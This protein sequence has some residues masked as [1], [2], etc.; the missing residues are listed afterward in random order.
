VIPRKYPGATG[1][2][3]G[4]G[5]S[6]TDADIE[7]IRAARQADRG[8]VFAANRAHEFVPADVIHGCNYQFWHRWWPD[9]R[10]HPADR[11]TT[12]PELE[13]IYPGLEYIAERWEPG[14]S[15]DPAWIAAHHG[16][17]PQL[18]NIAYLYGCTRLLLVGWDMRFHGKQDNRTYVTRR[19]LGE[20]DLTLQHWP[21]TGPNGELEGLI[22]E[23]ET[24]RPAEYGIEI[25]NCTPGSAL[26]CFPF[27]EIDRALAT[28]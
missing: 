12:R 13:G 9:L 3:V 4:T 25:I 7:A 16:T 11:W 10:D 24:I 15:R 20:D 17:G 19:Y 28:P 27:M 8:R 2:V 26:R 21:R 5:P 23:M 22:R 18:V 14:L 6:I 1:I